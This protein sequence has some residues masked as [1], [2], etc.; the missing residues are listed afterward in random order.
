MPTCMTIKNSAP[1]S[2]TR[3][4]SC[5]IGHTYISLMEPNVPKFLEGDAMLGVHDAVLAVLYQ[6]FNPRLQVL[7]VADVCHQRLEFLRCKNN[8]RP[9]IGTSCKTQRSYNYKVMSLV[10]IYLIL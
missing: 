1:M 9:V 10:N 2:D 3:R 7:L 5:H 6:L 8:H 4:A